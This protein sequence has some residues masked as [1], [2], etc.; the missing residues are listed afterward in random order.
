MNIYQVIKIIL[1]NLRFLL[2][3]PLITAALVYFTTENLPVQYHSEAT[4]FTG[5]TSNTDL[6]ELSNSRVDFFA[7][8]NAYNN[9]L[10]IIRSRNVLEET[11]MRLLTQHLML[12]HAQADIISQEAFAALQELTPDEVKKLIVKNNF[13]KSYQ[14][15][16]NYIIQDKKNF[17]YGLLNYSHPHYSIQALTGIKT[18]RLESSDLLR[19]SFDSDDPGIC[20]NTIKILCEVSIKRYNVLKSSQ[21]GSAVGYFEAKLK[22]AA[23]KLRESEDRLLQFNTQNEIINYY[24]QTKHVSSQQEKIEVRLQEIKMEY[25][26]SQAVLLKL[27]SETEKRYDINLRNRDIM[28]LR[29]Q[30]IEVNNKIVENELYKN[31]NS[32]INEKTLARRKRSLESQ[33]SNKI[34]SIYKYETNSQGIEL[35]KILGEWLDALKSHESYSALYSSMKE[36]E[37]EFMKQYQQYAPLGAILKRIEREI[38]VNEKEYLETLH[39]LGLAR[40]KQQS[41]D[42]LSDMKIMD[43]PQL[44]INSISS[45]RK[46]YVI[47]ATLFSAIFYLLILFLLELL[48]Q[49]IKTPARLHKHTEL[50]II[51]SFCK[52]KNKKHLNLELITE[53]ASLFIHEK[54]QLIPLEQPSQKPLVIQIISHWSGA[55]KSFLSQTLQQ[56][57]Q[58]SGEAVIYHD[59]STNKSSPQS[60]QGNLELA[61]LKEYHQ[62]LG[63]QNPTSNILICELPV[64]SDGIVNPAILQKADMSILVVQAGQTWTEADEFYLVKLKKLISNNFFA[65]L[66]QAQADNI[67]G[68]FG[69]MPKKRSAIRR[70]VKQKILSRFI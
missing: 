16:T 51:G 5:I 21:T 27:E 25:E 13:E 44:P 14:N 12:D 30:L 54:I 50:E 18:V 20:F 60:N 9:V 61:K 63:D 45:K 35:Q 67:E 17:I 36:R 29:E 40:L 26:A 56:H 31:E 59:F 48:D 33:L 69:E 46:L 15:I 28:V 39:H 19:I 43:A 24:E 2:V 62:L 70:F 55:G 8:Q 6:E 66:T 32:K 49:R 47:I 52:A 7:T 38:N 3:I 41:A 42:M 1:R 68:M 11:S 57:L 37:K 58:Q 4:I 10:T 23:E 65:V 64:I 22:E 53:R 34:D